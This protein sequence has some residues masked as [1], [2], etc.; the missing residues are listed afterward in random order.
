MKLYLV[1]HGQSEGNITHLYQGPDESLTELGHQ[2]AEFL[3]NRFGSISLDGILASPYKRAQQT[4]AYIGKKKNLEITTNALL[5][6]KSW[7]S[8]LT[9][10]SRND[11][12]IQE[13]VNLL[14]EKEQS[15]PEFRLSDEERFIDIRKRAVQFL[16]AAV[17]LKE[18]HKALCVVSHGHFL[19]VIIAVVIHGPEVPAKLFRDFF[20]TTSM[21]NT[22]ITALE[23]T[24]K[25]WHILTLNDHA[26]LG[27]Y[28][29]QRG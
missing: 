14:L 19:R 20:S 28:H 18:K 21:H 22:G 26:H 25:G 23:H 8:V 17:S 1:R 6:E 29:R 3:A 9:G 24:E 4:A 16:D 27:D 10:K 5:V 11:P 7:G 13:Q 12:T 15:E 2:Q